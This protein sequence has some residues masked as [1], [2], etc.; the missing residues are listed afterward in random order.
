MT[1]LQKP[2]NLVLSYL[3]IAGGSCACLQVAGTITYSIAD[4]S[5]PRHTIFCQLQIMNPAMDRKQTS[6]A[7]PLNQEDIIGYRIW[8]FLK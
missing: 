5:G 2:F 7:L 6:G 3:Y 1:S 8:R 4:W